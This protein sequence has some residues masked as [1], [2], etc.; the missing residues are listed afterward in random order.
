MTDNKLIDFFSS[1]H[2]NSRLY[3]SVKDIK[4]KNK[5][6]K[7][8]PHSSF[9]IFLLSCSLL[10]YYTIS[11]CKPTTPPPPKGRNNNSN[12]NNAKSPLSNVS[13][14]WSNIHI[15]PIFTIH[16]KPIDNPTQKP[17]KASYNN[18]GE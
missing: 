10:N 15:L 5:N 9:L 3:I 8:V 16:L 7:G 17:L 6:K 12:N 13:V 2:Q 4:N 14:V 11:F 1:S 18:L